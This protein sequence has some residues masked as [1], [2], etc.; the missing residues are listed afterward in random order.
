MSVCMWFRHSS[1]RCC[2]CISRFE[3]AIEV[4]D[5]GYG[6]LQVKHARPIPTD[7]LNSH[8]SLHTQ[9][10]GQWLDS[11][12]MSL[13]RLEGRLRSSRGKRKRDL[14]PAGSRGRELI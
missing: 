2:P 6:K 3:R 7:R 10:L 5:S 1:K 8:A 9:N 12:S 14:T 4:P 13:E 11:K